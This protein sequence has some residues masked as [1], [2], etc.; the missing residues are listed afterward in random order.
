[1][2][3]ATSDID[4]SS[5]VLARDD[6]QSNERQKHPLH[7][8]KLKLKPNTNILNSPGAAEPSWKEHANIGLCIALFFMLWLFPFAIWLNSTSSSSLIELDI[9]GRPSDWYLQ[10]L[11]LQE[12]HHHILRSKSQ[13]DTSNRSTGPSSIRGNIS[14]ANSL[15]EAA[16]NLDSKDGNNDILSGST[17]I[18]PVLPYASDI[19]VQHVE[20][21]TTIQST[22]TSQ[23][24]DLDKELK[25]MRQKVIYSRD[26]RLASRIGCNWRRGPN[27]LALELEA[28]ESRQAISKMQLNDPKESEQN[29]NLHAEDITLDVSSNIVLHDQGGETKAWSPKESKKP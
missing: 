18:P 21:I 3:K 7:Q 25:K 12:F 14:A 8:R 27:P 4:A 29:N 5:H 10:R 13:T 26:N 19:V 15:V 2:C 24:Q 6:W 20:E 1:M 23:F 16:G 11:A 22:H 17:E 9:F 28:E